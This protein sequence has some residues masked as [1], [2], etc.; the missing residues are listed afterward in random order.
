MNP[1]FQTPHSPQAHGSLQRLFWSPSE[2]RLRAAWR[3]LL[4]SLLMIFLLV[5]FSAVG[6]ILALLWG[7]L[8]LSTLNVSSPLAYAISLPAIV[9][10]TW[11]ARRVFDRRSFTSLGLEL[12]GAPLRDLAFGIGLTG[13]MMGLTF[14]LEIGLGWLKLGGWAWQGSAGA[15][16][17]RQLLAI[18]LAFVIV[19]FQEELLSRGYQ[20]QNLVDGLN[21]PAGVVISSIIFSLL[22]SLNPGAGWFSTLGLFLSGVFLAY[23]WVRTRQL[24]LPIGLHIGWNIFEGPVFGFA[25]SGS[26]TFRLIQH[27][28]SG[29]Q[30]ITG[31]SFGPEAGAILLPALALGSLGIWIYTRNPGP[32]QRKKPVARHPPGQEPSVGG[33]EDR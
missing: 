15:G 8:N 5:V 23:G 14:V 33:G 16:W 22:H 1:E 20:L 18:L 3:L 31:G 7:G 10:S 17:V 29:P 21:L 26:H 19:G 2:K 27:T 13:A 25:V 30:W 9:I 11:F 4:Q 32:L 12:K 6:A 24:W 28:V